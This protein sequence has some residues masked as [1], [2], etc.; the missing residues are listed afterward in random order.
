M[1]S[2]LRRGAHAALLLALAA[3]G[4]STPRGPG[5]DGGM[6]DL[7]RDMPPRTDSG[8]RPDLGPRDQGP[9]DAGPD[10]GSDGDECSPTAACG[11]GLQCC[12]M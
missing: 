11:A 6:I 1:T 10:L 8:P 3:C 12:V 9:A 5:V 7:S 4:D 2:H